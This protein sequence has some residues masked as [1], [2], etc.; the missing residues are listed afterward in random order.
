MRFFK[1]LG[2]LIKYKPHLY[3]GNVLSWM[4]VEAFPLLPVLIVKELLDS[5]TYRTELDGSFW[6]LVLALV[7]V[8]FG[9]IIFTYFGVIF[10]V[11]YSFYA[12]GLM[13]LNLLQG[14]L[15]RP[16][17]KALHVT[18][19]E[20]QERF[21]G[22]VE[23]IEEILGWPI[24]VLAKLVSTLLAVII[25]FIVNA[26]I[27][28]YVVIPLFL[29]SI[30]LQQ[31]RK[32]VYKYRQESRVATE[33]VVGNMGEIFSSIQA[34][35]LS[36]S[37]KNILDNFQKLSQIRHKKALKDSLVTK[38]LDCILSNVV[39]LGTGLILLISASWV[40]SG[41]LTLGEFALVINYWFLVADFSDNFGKMVATYHQARV[42]HERVIELLD[43]DE[44]DLLVMPQSLKVE[45]AKADNV[46][47]P[48]LTEMRIENLSYTFPNTNIG[49]KNIDLEIT[50]G[51]FTVIAGKIGSGKT[52]LVRTIL[53]LLPKNNGTIYWN[54]VEIE[55]LDK[56]LIPPNVAYTSHVPHLFSDTVRENILLGVKGNSDNDVSTAIK[57]AV[58]EQDLE[59]LEQGLD[60]VIGPRGVKLSGG[61]LQRVAA[62]RMFATKS[63]LYVFD[64]ISSA[65]DVNTE[66][67]LWKRLFAKG[68][69][70]CIAVSNRVQALEKADQ[71][72]VL[73]EGKIVGKG[74]LNELLATCKEFQN[75]LGN[76]ELSA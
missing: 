40:L 48:E 6:L 52:T 58:L 70:T 41:E 66:S 68:D 45:A 28:M 60:T 31:F 65:L 21:N 34:I 61:Q 33:K 36:G 55:G 62:A 72:I 67:T 63:Q 38:L 1:V 47:L 73:D 13:R 24:D 7:G 54:G 17:C 18:P 59:G 9:R 29:V 3:T 64:D 10:G 16:G 15:N 35:Q 43:G 11:L 53:G 57:A 69:A 51:S 20:A 12:Q 19:S 46:V 42:S 25:L 30:S 37:E 75:I 26:K 39:H 22:D 76:D 44:N 2:R 32:K 27:T 71:I 4:V 74:K 23:T 56:Q 50:K 49:I 14:I 8:Y 5:L